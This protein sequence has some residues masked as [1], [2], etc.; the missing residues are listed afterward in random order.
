MIV[1]RS[2]YDSVI[3]KGGEIRDAKSLNLP[4]NIVSLQVLGRCFAFFTLRDQLVLQ[5]QQLLRVEEMQRADWLICLVWI[6]D[7]L[8]VWWKTSKKSK[9]F[10]QSRDPR[11]T[12]RTNFLQPA[13]DI[14]A[15]RQ[16]DH[17]RWK[18]WNINPKLATKQCC[19]T[20]WGF[21]YLVF[22][23][24]NTNQELTWPCNW[25]LTLKLAKLFTERDKA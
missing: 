21:L 16:V 14:V 11:A 17:A 4:R 12:F 10:A 2:I 8:R 22:R 5:Q 9:F 19:A 7:K 15:V 18:T 1:T 13:T 23:R 3:T 25:A 6:P 24:L 20:R